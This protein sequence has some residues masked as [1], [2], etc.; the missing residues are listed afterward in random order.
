MMTHPM[1][2]LLLG[3]V[4]WQRYEILCSN[5]L[6]DRFDLSLFIFELNVVCD[7]DYYQRWK[8]KRER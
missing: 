6:L 3:S 2:K 7:S 8:R 1:I 4:L 5:A